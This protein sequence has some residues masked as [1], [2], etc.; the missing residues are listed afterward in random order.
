MEFRTYEQAEREPY[1]RQYRH[2]PIGALIGLLI[3]LSAMAGAAILGYAVWAENRILAVLLTGFLE[4]MSLLFAL[5]TGNMFRDRLRRSNWL[6]R[7]SANGISIKFRSYLNHQFDANDVVVA[8]IRYSEIEYA[9]EHRVAQDVPGSSTGETESRRLRFAEFKLR[10]E[11]DLQKLDAQL[12]VERSRKGPMAGRFIRRR[13]THRDYPVRVADGFLRVNW[14]VRPRFPQFLKDISGRVAIH[15]A[16]KTS[17][18]FRRLKNATPRDQEDALLKL[19][20]AGDRF[21]AIRVIKE[22]YGYD[23]KRAAQFLDELS[24]NKGGGVRC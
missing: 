9:R 14:S 22:I 23:T 7:T 21:G 17:E 12:A 18:D 16:I 3:A 8:S 15:D 1:D 4:L 10:D 5:M 20:A 13:T 2:A 19:V 24:K 6:V 11:S